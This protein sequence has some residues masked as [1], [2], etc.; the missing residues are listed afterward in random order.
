MG[1]RLMQLSHRLRLVFGV[2]AVAAVGVVA[3]L[4]LANQ[5]S[6]S[7][8]PPPAAGPPPDLRPAPDAAINVH[9][10]TH[11][12][13]AGWAFKTYKNR[14][15][16]TCT[17]EVL[18]GGGEGGTCY[19]PGTLFRKSPLLSYLGS[20]QT[21]DDITQ[22]DNAWVWGLA[23]KPIT[24]VQLVLTDCTIRDLPVDAEGIYGDVEGPETL[25]AGVWPYKVIGLAADGHVVVT[26]KVRLGPPPTAQ[27]RAQGITAPPVPTRCA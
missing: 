15:G 21:G 13:T 20:R 3:G 12:P 19:A 7:P 17:V 22:W 10:P 2:A 27:A 6:T 5:G 23:E 16:E 24:H 4:I 26:E 14:A 9:R 8:N 25:H 18:P 1:A 11:A